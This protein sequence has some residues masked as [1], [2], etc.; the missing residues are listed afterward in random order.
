MIIAEGNKP[1]ALRQL[2]QLLAL[3]RTEREEAAVHFEL[4]RVADNPVPHHLR[5]MTLYKSL[6]DRTP[7]HIYRM[8]LDE[9]EKEGRV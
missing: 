8:R 9:L 6:Y 7:Q 1:E 4:R 3:A 2:Q 5:A